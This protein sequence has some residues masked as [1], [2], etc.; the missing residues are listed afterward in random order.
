MFGV[1]DGVSIIVRLHVGRM[2]SE[3]EIWPRLIAPP[4]FLLIASCFLLIPYFPP[5][6]QNKTPKMKKKGMSYIRDIDSNQDK[7]QV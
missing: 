4:L 5:I 1:G 3:R 7:N 6:Q 2:W